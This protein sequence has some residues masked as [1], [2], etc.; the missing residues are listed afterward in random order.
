MPRRVIGERIPCARSDTD[1]LPAS[2]R[3]ATYGASTLDHMAKRR[4]PSI[5]LDEHI[6]PELKAQFSAAGF[7]VIR[8]NES[9]YRGRDEHDYLAEM[10]SRNEIFVTEDERFVDDVLD[11]GLRR[12]AG[13]VWSPETLDPEQRIGFAELATDWIRSL[14]REEGPFAMRGTLLYP[15]KDGPT[16]LVDDKDLLLISWDALMAGPSV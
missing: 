15:S 12:H 14:V 16:I 2:G 13:I 5:C 9:S 7:R 3:V 8:A 4:L 6:P 11:S 10:Y 1:P